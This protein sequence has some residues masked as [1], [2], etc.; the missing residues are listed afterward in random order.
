M[1]VDLTEREVRCLLTLLD[2]EAVRGRLVR[3]AVKALEDKLERALQPKEAE[4]RC[5]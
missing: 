5:S 2:Q 3:E 1:Q 4:T